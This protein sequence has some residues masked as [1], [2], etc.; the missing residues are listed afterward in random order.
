MDPNSCIFIPLILTFN[1]IEERI[2]LKN[3]QLR[4]LNGEQLIFQIRI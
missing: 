2:G 3:T 1:V 4:S